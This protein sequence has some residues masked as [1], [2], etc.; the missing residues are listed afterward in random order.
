MASMR[1]RITVKYRV[2]W[3][4]FFWPASPSFMSAS[5]LGMTIVSNCMM[6]DAVMYGMI[7]M[8]KM[9]TRCSPPPVK[10]L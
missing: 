1:A 4:T 7:P 2:Y 8:A 3:L 9:A 10:R 6:M 5:S